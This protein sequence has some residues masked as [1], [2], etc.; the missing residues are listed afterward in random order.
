M[1]QLLTLNF[2]LSENLLVCI[3][4]KL[5]NLWL[6]TTLLGEEFGAK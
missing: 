1:E 2:Y 5:Q 4:F 3:F 6:K